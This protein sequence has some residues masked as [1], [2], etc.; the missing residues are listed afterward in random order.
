MTI[1]D[2]IAELFQAEAT[3]KYKIRSRMKFSAVESVSDEDSG[4]DEEEERSGEDLMEV[5][6][7]ASSGDEEE[8]GLGGDTSW[9]WPNRYRRLL[10]LLNE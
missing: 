10:A 5:D 2:N 6:S 7:D 9:H 4:E 3:E 8:V 1:I